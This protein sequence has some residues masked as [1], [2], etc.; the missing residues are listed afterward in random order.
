MDKENPSVWVGIKRCGCCVA[1]VVDQPDRQKHVR[2]CK[3]E[4]LRDGLS[5][6]Y[7]T[8]EEWR[9]KYMPVFMG[10]SHEARSTE[11]ATAPVA[12]FAGILSVGNR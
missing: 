8:W 7:G 1:V 11:S 10:C 9:T 2:Q 3:E 4:F 12:D 5:V 6:I